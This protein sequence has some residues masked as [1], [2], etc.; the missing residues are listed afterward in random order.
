MDIWQLMSSGIQNIYDQNAVAMV[1]VISVLLIVCG[2][3]CVMSILDFRGTALDRDE[4]LIK[5]YRRREDL[6][7]DWEKA[8]RSQIHKA[9]KGGGF[10]WDSDD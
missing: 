10:E 2:L 1:G 3:R 4:K 8:K 5:D 7:G 9:P 6:G